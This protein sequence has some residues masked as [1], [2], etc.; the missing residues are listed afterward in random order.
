MH[1]MRVAMLESSCLTAM[2]A[3]MATLIFEYER[4]YQKM[5]REVVGEGKAKRKR[6]Q[7]I[8]RLPPTTGNS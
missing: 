8:K 2:Q 7:S 5:L 6:E 3:V 4:R 1:W